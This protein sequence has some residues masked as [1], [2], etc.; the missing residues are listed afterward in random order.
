M[1]GSLET[2]RHNVNDFTTPVHAQAA[3]EQYIRF[4]LVQLLYLKL[5]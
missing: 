4:R 5:S 2:E 3:S 1:I